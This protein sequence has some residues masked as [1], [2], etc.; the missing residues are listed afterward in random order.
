M[1]KRKN[2]KIIIFVVV[3]SV[4]TSCGIPK[5]TQRT[6][7]KSIAQSY[8]YSG[9]TLKVTPLGWHE[10]FKDT[11]LV[12]LI[13][14][15]FANNQELNITLLEV[16][17]LKNE[18]QAKKGEYL[19]FLN[20][21]G[22]AG[23]DKVGRFTSQ[24]GNDANTDIEPGVK[25]PDVLSDFKVNAQ[26]TWEVDIWKKLR[27]SKKAAV[28]RYLASIEGQNFM[29]T[30]LISEIASSYYELMALQ[31]ELR[32]LEQNIDIQNNALRTVR[33]QKQAANV[34]ELAVKKFEAEVLKNRSKLFFVRQQ[35]VEAENKI[36]FLV[37]RFPQPIQTPYMD[38]LN[39]EPAPIEAGIPAQLFENRPD[40]LQAE[41]ELEASK[42]DVKAAK[43]NFYPSL[44]INA[45]LGQQAYKTVKMLSPESL[46]F[47]L[48]GD[49]VAPLINK[50]AI[51]TQYLNANARQVQA[52]YNY[53][54]TVLAAFIDVSN[55]LS[56]MD[57]LQKA[58][59]LQIEQ[60]ETLNVSI[61]I[62]S[63]L[64]LS[65]RADYMEVLLTQR[66]A[67]EAKLDLLETKKDL[68]ISHVSMYRALG[69]GW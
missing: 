61:R 4:L 48:A 27:N 56:K 33:L 22:G 18:I 62:S 32:I 24:G 13:E 14:T 49:M 35:I 55:Q 30:N 51:R 17:Q 6:E 65:A 10:F 38:F 19:P 26:L 66:D 50:N 31:S 23:V 8:N 16:S 3:S 36:N 64:F 44:G 20:L 54:R 25:T 45:N 21:G 41:F 39:T 42:L 46:I 59:D 60:V 52:V 9:D 1:N 69:G 7:N 58:Y 68:M 15:G 57:N 28:N 5:Y 12:S 2:S 53:E 11:L 37:G 67:L 40:I 43:A 34:T 63:S 47:G 29:K